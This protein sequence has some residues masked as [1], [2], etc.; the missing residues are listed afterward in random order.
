[1]NTTLSG[2]K[3]Q[4]GQ[5][6]GNCW[7][8]T[9]AVDAEIWVTQRCNLE[10]DGKSALREVLSGEAGRKKLAFLTFSRPVWLIDSY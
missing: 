10:M 9:T 7:Q 4:S 5:A 1:M 8:S 3:S 6:L 2:K